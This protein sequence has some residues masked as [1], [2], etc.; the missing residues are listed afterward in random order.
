VVI[1][2]WN[3][4]VKWVQETWHSNPAVFGGAIGV[5]LTFLL[6]D[7]IATYIL[8]GFGKLVR[9]SCDLVLRGVAGLALV[10]RFILLNRYR[11]ELERRVSV[12]KN[13]WLPSSKRLS[14]IFVPVSATAGDTASERIELRE[15]FLRHRTIVIVGD[16]GSGKTTGLKSIALD[17]L[18]DRLFT[19]TGHSLIPVF[20]ELRQLAKSGQRLDAFLA[21]QLNAMR[22]PKA[23]RSL[24]RLE[25]QSRLV[26]LLDGLDEVDDE[27]RADLFDQLQS[28]LDRQ[29]RNGPGC[30]II[31]TSRPVG[32]DGQLSGHIIETA[33][34]AEFTPADIRRFLAQWPYDEKENK[35]ADD[36]A[37]QIT[38]RP[39]ILKICSNPL[40]LTIVAWLYSRPDFLIPDSREEFY[41]QCVEALLRAWDKTKNLEVNRIPPELKEAFLRA[42]AYESLVARQLDFSDGFLLERVERHLSASA[43]YKDLDAV[44]FKNELYRSGLV[45]RLR[46]GEAFFAHKTLAEFLAARYLHSRFEL[47][48]D[49]W[50]EA[51]G[52][53]LEVCSLYVAHPD[54]AT[55]RVR[56]LVLIAHRASDWNGAL[57]LAG[58]ATNCPADD[59]LR[60]LA[61][62]EANSAL[63]YSLEQRALNALARFGPPA[64]S[65]LERMLTSGDRTLA[66][67]VLHTLSIINTPWASAHLIQ[68][69]T[70]GDVDSAAVEALTLMGENGVP[71]VERVLR[72]STV[73][74]NA[75]VSQD[76][77]YRAC[78]KIL[79]NIGSLEAVHAIAAALLHSAP[80][81]FMQ[82]HV[83]NAKSDKIFQPD[84]L[85]LAFAV[86][87][88]LDRGPM[89]A[90]FEASEPPKD[91]AA[92]LS[93]ATLRVK[94]LL[95]W[96][97]P[98][99][100][101]E[102]VYQ[103]TLYATVIASIGRALEEN[104][105]DTIPLLEQFW[106][107]LVFPALMVECAPVFDAL[108]KHLSSQQDANVLIPPS[109]SSRLAHIARE[110]FAGPEKLR[111]RWSQVRGTPEED[112][113]IKNKFLAQVI[114]ATG[115][116]IYLFPVAIAIYHGLLSPHVL[117]LYILMLGLGIMFWIAEKEFLVLN[118][119]SLE[120]L[121]LGPMLRTVFRD[122]SAEIGKI[123][124]IDK[125]KVSDRAKLDLPTTL[126]MVGF[127]VMGIASLFITTY[128]I[129]RVGGWTGLCLLPTAFFAF[130]N[131]TERNK[132]VLLHRRNDLLR[133]VE[134]L[135][136]Q[137]PKT[138]VLP[139]LVSQ[140]G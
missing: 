9:W 43:K 95:G 116:A 3:E 24:A 57:I 110:I 42:F 112:I 114:Y 127:A 34:M 89:R 14:D 6:K 62:I 118:L 119:L 71:I 101:I 48:A 31:V 87:R 20:V 35:S 90:A 4:I 93:L 73:S 45:G 69:L 33:R 11:H 132:I 81:E 84:L 70:A 139:N 63:W 44:V 8:G 19:S 51:P 97:L 133:L 91:I 54:T 80:D 5:L 105:R 136:R 59:R 128:A 123:R 140:S 18:N 130:G 55:E 29:A 65:V 22:F 23:E 83:F 88:I 30:H 100:P 82:P 99:I 28:L 68:A 96:S 25:K 60:L 21:E 115:S 46:N 74:A 108:R 134:Y 1:A 32:Y 64:Q 98:W 79:E 49:R 104:P 107:R 2:L 16:P 41:A 50:R 39:P 135:E 26:Y 12:I 131:Q 77:L 106:V 120:T 58:E 47:L 129:Y 78:G 126:G 66:A 137:A 103:R 76:R 109:D 27:K 124:Q 38:T 52:E 61:D 121:M 7:V 122:V 17:C 40:M 85:P 113:V 125:T 37:F 111:T 67:R 36:L 56:Q 138:P 13:I 15:L 10:D 53:W 75:G 86:S 102:K 94:N 72:D 92:Q 117:W